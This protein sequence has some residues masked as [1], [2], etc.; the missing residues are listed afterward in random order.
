MCNCSPAGRVYP[1]FARIETHHHLYPGA[2][3]VAMEPYNGY[4]QP[5]DQLIQARVYRLHN[6]NNLKIARFK[7]IF[8][9]ATKTDRLDERK[10]LELFQLLG[11]PPVTKAVLQEVGA[12]SEANAHLKRLTR[13]RRRLVNERVR[14]LNTL[15]ADLQ[16]VCRGLLEI[17]MDVGNQ[18]FLFLVETLFR[19]PLCMVA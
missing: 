2:V 15:H 18:W 5:L 9:G 17:T 12:V 13:R 11:H 16:A 3:A 7:E 10:G 1:L 19:S 6:I 8:P 14:V 4:A